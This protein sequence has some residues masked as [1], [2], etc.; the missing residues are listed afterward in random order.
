MWDRIWFGEHIWS[1]ESRGLVL[2]AWGGNHNC[3]EMPN[4][5]GHQVVHLSSWKRR[6]EEFEESLQ[7]ALLWVFCFPGLVVGGCSSSDKGLLLEMDVLRSN[8]LQ[9]RPPFL[10]DLF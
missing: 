6:E 7:P 1:I 2:D 8:T 9:S 3:T 10:I 5:C 4:N